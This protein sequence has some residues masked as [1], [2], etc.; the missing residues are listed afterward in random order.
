M[1]LLPWAWTR[2]C[3]GTSVSAA[4]CASRRFCRVTSKAFSKPLWDFTLTST[5]PDVLN[6]FAAYF[7][8]ACKATT[9]S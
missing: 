4:C 2:N 8:K 5:W 6:V 3:P 7:A 9:V 1:Q